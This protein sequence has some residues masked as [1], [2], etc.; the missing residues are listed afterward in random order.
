GR[1]E[2]QVR[3]SVD[4]GAKLLCGGQS[5]PGE[6][7][8]FEPTVLANTGPGMAAFDEET[9]GPVAAIAVADSDEEIIRLANATPFGLSLSIWGASKDR[10]VAIAK[11]ITSGA[12][13]INAVTASD[14]RL[15]FGGTKKSGYGR[16]LAAA[17]V[18]EFSNI[19]SY[20][21]A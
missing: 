21:A 4:A 14:A 8:F 17:G 20:W 10:G 15:P 3:R 1:V 19:R 9:F 16:E 18:R 5:L 12:A 11:R 6:G 13:F 7:F 2:D